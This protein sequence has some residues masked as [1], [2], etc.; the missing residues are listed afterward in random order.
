MKKVFI[1][2]FL[3]IVGAVVLIF[4]ARLTADFSATRHDPST[5]KLRVTYP[6][7]IRSASIS[8]GVQTGIVALPDGEEVKFWFVS[9]HVAGP[10]CT[11]FDFD[12]GTRQYIYG[13][14]FCCE[15][16]IPAD[17]V[18]TKQD[19]IAFLEAHDES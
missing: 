19:L 12:D 4:R 17:Q 1:V 10:G 16:Q 18:K 3:L 2:L 15:V 13:S 8:S 5:L 6:P 7:L 14:Y 11:R 9:H